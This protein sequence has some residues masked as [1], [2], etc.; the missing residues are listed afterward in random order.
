MYQRLGMVK[1]KSGETVEAGVVRG[2]DLV[3]AQR[4]MEL[5]WHKGD[6][7]NWQNAQVLERDL[8]LD[9][10][11]YVLHRDGAPFANIMTIELNGVGLFGHVWTQPAD[12]QQGASSRLMRLQMQDFVERGGQ[13]L[14]LNTG[15]A[16]VAYNMYANFGFTGIEAE[17]GT[18]AY[19]T[20][21]QAEFEAAYFASRTAP[22][23]V[24]VQPLNWLHWPAATPLFVGDYPG[25]VRCL[26]LGLIGR[27][28]TEGAFLPPLLDATERQQKH[29]PPAVLALVNQAT[30][31]VVGLAA[32][33]W[34]PLWPDTCLVDCYC[35]PAYWGHAAELFGALP[36]PQADRTVAY[37][38]VGNAAKATL[39]AQVGFKP[40]ATL[41]DWLAIDTVK[42]KR[43]DVVI[44]EK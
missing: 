20:K 37:V 31:A 17:N 24:E 14:F 33:S 2:P 15:Y 28:I 43:V 3:W 8:G 10:C 44:M 12:R 34:D 30:T 5:L 22:S 1:L 42:T 11:F 41:P 39:F 13:A 26:P 36:L 19:Y 21:T 38:D 16:S 29:E 6:P 40:V 18:M 9:A 25:L 35:H 4:L 23:L 32:W 7:W 27:V